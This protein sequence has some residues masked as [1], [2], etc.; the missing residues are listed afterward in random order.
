MAVLRQEA[1]GTL[2]LQPPIPLNAAGGLDVEAGDVNGDGRADLVVAIFDYPPQPQVAV[3]LQLGN[4]AFA[5]PQFLSAQSTQSPLR[6]LAVAIG[7]LNGDG[8][9]DV[10]AT[11][12]GNSPSAHLAVFYQT[13]DGRLGAMTP[14]DT[15]EVPAA[16]GKR[17][18]RIAD[19]N[20][21]GRADLIVEHSG[22][23]VFGVYLQQANG[24]LAPE[25]R[26]QAPYGGLLTP[27]VMAV[28]D[29]SRDGRTD[30]VIAGFV[31]LQRP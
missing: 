24:A 18:V 15:Y 4:G 27:K 8:R 3:L 5:A 28:G 10:V 29:I 11:S 19:V 14:L 6:A 17:G 7:D 2:V 25:Q 12:G 16:W 13:S 23:F 20:N 1:N 26:F 30:V 9:N 31:L 21:D 22:W